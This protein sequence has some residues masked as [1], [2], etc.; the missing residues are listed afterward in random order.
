MTRVTK[1]L[2]AVTVPYC[3]FPDIPL[4]VFMHLSKGKL[5]HHAVGQ[6]KKCA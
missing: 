5:C 6:N 3:C 1:P 2:V 4:T